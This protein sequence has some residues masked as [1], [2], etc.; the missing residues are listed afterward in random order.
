MAEVS[1]SSASAS[2]SSGA[3]GGLWDNVK[4][5]GIKAGKRASM[6]AHK[7][8]LTAEL[9]WIDNRI[10]TRKE[11]LGIELYDTLVV[12]AD[13]DPTFIID[14]GDT[15]DHIRGDFVTCFKDNKALVQKR[16]RKQQQLV[17][18]KEQKA[19]AYPKVPCETFRGQAANGL[20][21]ANFAR[22]ETQTKT[23]IALLEQEMTLHK[24]KFGVAVYDLMVSLEDTQQWLPRDR[25]VRFLYDQARRDITHLYQERN[26]KEA[27]LA[28]LSLE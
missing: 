11:T 15:L 7:A 2:S 13:Q 9:L 24:K 23:K 10:R 3:G 27:E 20:K 5:Q 19:V 16:A 8:K 21:A 6:A 1:A 28:V 25:D 12:L 26:E 17:E 22:Q 14:D 4:A 18:L